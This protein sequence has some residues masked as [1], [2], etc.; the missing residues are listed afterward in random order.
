MESKSETKRKEI[1]SGSSEQSS[2][3]TVRV[4]IECEDF[5]NLMEEYRWSM[6]EDPEDVVERYHAVI[7]YIDNYISGLSQHYSANKWQS[8][9]QEIKEYLIAA[10]DGSMSRNNSEQLAAELL[11]KL[12]ENP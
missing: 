5:Y 1:Q 10:S 2:E 4:S 3:D 11:D 12:T 7:D 8:V 9:I 6:E